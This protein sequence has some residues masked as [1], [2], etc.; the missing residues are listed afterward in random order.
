VPA[1]DL[2]LMSDR[3]TEV[4]RIGILAMAILFVGLSYGQSTIRVWGS[5]QMSS[6]LRLWERG[7]QRHHSGVVFKN[8]LHGTVTGIAGLYTGVAD[9]AVMGREI[10]PV[11][12]SAYEAVFSRKP[13]ETEVATGSYDKPKVTFALVVYV[14]KS[15]P[16]AS[17]T[18]DQLAAVFGQP[19]AGGAAA[20]RTWDQLGLAG[21]WAGQPIH[22]YNFD[23]ENDKSIFFRRRVFR[24]RYRWDMRTHEF[25]NVTKAGETLDAGKQILEALAQDPRGIAVSNPHYANQNVKAVSL[26]VR[27]K[28]VA[29]SPETVRNR[30]YPLTRAVYIYTN[31]EHSKGEAVGAFLR[32]ILSEEGQQDVATDGSYVPLVP[33]II[34]V[35]LRSL[36]ER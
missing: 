34:S 4:L 20:M 21:E 2:V 16:C 5:P 6:V 31:P 3:Y 12:T 10:W 27:Y 19:V 7:F 23:Y 24:A 30:T 35:G 32:Y 28:A 11:E 29:A 1:W 25:F 14:H 26:E 17:L 36:G 22:T 8:E 15:N 13:I 33:E 9:L 18:L